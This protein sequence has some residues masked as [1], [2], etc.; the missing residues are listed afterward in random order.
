MMLPAFTS[1]HVLAFCA[2]CLAVCAASSLAGTRWQRARRVLAVVAALFAL[3]T[4][5]L[6]RHAGVRQSGWPLSSGA[7]V[8]VISAAA[9]VLWCLLYARRMTTAG[10][11]VCHALASALLV[12]GAIRWPEQLASPLSDSGPQP[13]S[14]VSRLLLALACG[15]MIE[16]GCLALAAL[17]MERRSP[18]HG[19][20]DCAPGSGTPVLLGFFLATAALLAHALGGLYARGVY[21]SWG[22]AE[23]WMLALWLVLAALWNGMT[24]AALPVQRLRRLT[25]LGLLM[26][27]LLFRSLGA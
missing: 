23:S 12:W 13:W 4:V 22:E 20:S 25:V 10:G 6:L 15:A 2:T 14:F 17:V 18:P 1:V 7:E 9:A 27:L 5:A 8:V 3:G 21:W 11:L 26:A 24:A 16:A 19:K